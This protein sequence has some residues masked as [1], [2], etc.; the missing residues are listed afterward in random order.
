MRENLHTS[1]CPLWLKL[2][3]LGLHMLIITVHLTL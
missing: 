2:L 3:Y 1:L